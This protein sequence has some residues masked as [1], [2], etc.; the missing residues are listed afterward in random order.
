MQSPK[1][2]RILSHWGYGEG[3]YLS[4]RTVDSHIR[5]IRQKL[6]AADSDCIETVYGVGYRLRESEA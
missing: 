3:H 6:K 2:P 1:Q 5:R 4:D